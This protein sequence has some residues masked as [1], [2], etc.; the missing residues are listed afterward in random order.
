M[1]R[2]KI[3]IM[4]LVTPIFLVMPACNPVSEDVEDPLW[5]SQHNEK[6]FQ[7]NFFHSAD[8]RF[9]HGACDEAQCHGGDLAGGNSGSPSCTK[10]H[11]EQWTVF[12]TGLHTRV[13][14]GYYHNIHVDDA[15]DTSSNATWFAYCSTVLC[16]ESDLEGTQGGPSPNFA[17]VY[18]CKDCHKGFR[19]SIPPPR[20][21]K[22]KEGQWHSSGSCAGDACHGGDGESDGVG[23]PSVNANGIANGGPACSRCHDGDK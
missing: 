10:C 7:S 22:K 2:D 18:S 19:G 15:A 6:P 4:I 8:Y 11:N 17:Y 3:L 16:H 14:S 1:I 9:P 20:H 5:N 21:T 23:Y 12:E 13:V